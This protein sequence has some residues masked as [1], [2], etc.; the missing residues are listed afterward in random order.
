MHRERVC[1]KPFNRVDTTQIVP[2]S[3]D[4]DLALGPDRFLT[5]DSTRKWMNNPS[6]AKLTGPNQPAPMTPLQDQE[7][8][9]LKRTICGTKNFFTDALRTKMG[10]DK[11][12]KEGTTASGIMSSGVMSQETFTSNRE[13]DNMNRH[14]SVQPSMRSGV[15]EGEF[16][17]L[18]GKPKIS[19]NEVVKKGITS[20][21][22]FK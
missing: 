5:I 16:F 8:E 14:R 15:V 19:F 18:P 7:G 2:N 6:K 3:V 9:V 22:P 20:F 4:E 1:I 10:K 12:Q 11:L 17:G 13:R 21:S